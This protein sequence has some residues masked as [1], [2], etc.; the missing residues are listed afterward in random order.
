MKRAILLFIAVPLF[1]QTS[2]DISFQRT[3][4]LRNISGT[5]FN[6]G[7]AP[8]HPHIVNRGAWT[9]FW[10]GAFSA[11]YANESGPATHRSE[12]FSTNW[13]AGGAQ[14]AL[15]SRGL[16]MFR[17]RASLEPFTIKQRGYP[18]VLQWVS[19]ENGGPLLDSMRAQDLIGEV[20][21][22]LAFR[23]TTSSFVYLYAAP[24][25]DPAFGTVPYAQRASS[26]ELAE[27]PFAYD[28][29]ETTHD[30]TRVITA[31]FGSR[32]VTLEGSA[33]HDAVSHGR[34]TSFDGGGSIDSHSA[35]L[36][37]T[38]MRNVGLQLSSGKL[39]DARRKVSSASLTYGNQNAAASAIWTQR[40]APSG[41]KLTSGALEGTLR[42]SRS[43]LSARI[44]SVDRPRGFLARPD[45]WRTTHFTIGYI[46]D[47][48]RGPYRT[49]VGAN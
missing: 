25:G 26:E 16:V 30:S 46:F 7:D 27:A 9:T 36:T 29:A 19:P 35:R 8:W 31:G 44:E 41:D 45:I 14:R 38:P 12:A 33:F 20:A 22:D 48:M 3:F 23:T 17:G 5:S 10:G 15:G 37:I 18:Q 1:A 21:V 39:G 42:V 34:H 47:L 11:V 43:S 2:E 49:G 24:I 32:F 6:A 13:I 4:L 28:V 40:E